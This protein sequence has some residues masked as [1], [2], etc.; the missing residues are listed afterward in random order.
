MSDQK[1]YFRQAKQRFEAGRFYLSKDL[2]C[3]LGVCER[4][5]RSWIKAG[6]VPGTKIGRQIIIP[7]EA[8]LCMLDN[9]DTAMLVKV[10]DSACVLKDN[11]QERL[12]RSE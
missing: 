6:T 3:A 7:G 8:I 10:K 11:T 9:L 1:S 4:T 5:V 2:A 12:S